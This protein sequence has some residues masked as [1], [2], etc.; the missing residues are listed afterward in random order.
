MCTNLFLHLPFSLSI[1][2]EGEHRGFVQIY[3]LQATEL[4]YISG[5]SGHAIKKL[6]NT[7]DI[8]KLEDLDVILLLC[9]YYS[10][11]SVVVFGHFVDII[12]KA[13]SR[14]CQVWSLRGK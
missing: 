2:R 1:E 6:H 7:W 4:I 5:I 14:H 10:T 11:I 3:K 8:I 12:T 13:V 9:L